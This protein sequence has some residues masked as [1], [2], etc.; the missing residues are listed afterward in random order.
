MVR[1]AVKPIWSVRGPRCRVRECV[2]HSVCGTVRVGDAVRVRVR[3]GTV[4]VCGAVRVCVRARVRAC[5]GACRI[6]RSFS[7][8]SNVC[9][10]NTTTM[11]R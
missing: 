5:V 3:A 4:P 9:G 1:K 7:S 6:L 8:V 11:T 10:T 2:W